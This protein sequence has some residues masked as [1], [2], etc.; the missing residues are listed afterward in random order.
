[1]RNGQTALTARLTELD[2]SI[3]RT[4]RILD[5]IELIPGAKDTPEYD[6][7][8]NHIEEAQSILS[9]WGEETGW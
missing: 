4:L 3:V 7:I 6:E 8:L 2:A 1:M 9:E 5:R